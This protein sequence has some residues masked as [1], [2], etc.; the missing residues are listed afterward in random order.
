M[1]HIKHLEHGLDDGAGIPLDGAG[2]PL[3]GGDIAGVG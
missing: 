3:D 1:K 2:I